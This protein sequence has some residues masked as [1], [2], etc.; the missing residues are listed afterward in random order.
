LREFWFSLLFS[1][2]TY[3][4]LLRSFF[5]LCEAKRL[6]LHSFIYFSLIIIIILNALRR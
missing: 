6:P 5:S 2:E 4:K 3:S 1:D